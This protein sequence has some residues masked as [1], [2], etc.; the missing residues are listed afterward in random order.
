MKNKVRNVLAA[1]VLCMS[2]IA[3]PVTAYASTGS[4]TTPP[5]LSATLNDDKLAVEASD[6]MSGVEAVYVDDTRINSLVNGKGTVALKD[7]AGDG[8]EVTVYAVDY[9][10]N[11]SKEV[12]LDN[13]YYEE[14]AQTQAASSAAPQSSS[15]E[16][17]AA[18][19]PSS[20]SASGNSGSSQVAQIPSTSQEETE[21]SSESSATEDETESAVP[22]GAFTPEGTGTVLDSATEQEDDKQFYTIT[23]ADGNVFYLII[24]GKRD[25]ENVYFLNG[26]T[27]EDLLSLAQQDNGSESAIEVVTCNCA[28]KCEAGAVN[29]DCPVCKNDLNGCLGKVTEE[30]APEETEQPE[31]E[32]EKSGGNTGMIIFLVIA[33]VAAGGLG[34]YFKI[35]R[36]KQQAAMDED[37]F[38]DDG[39][40]EDDEQDLAYSDEPSYD[41]DEEP[42]KDG[43]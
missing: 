22:E 30:P 38:E 18:P 12:K 4:D 16:T 8:K 28:E 14:P 3:L 43:R 15:G 27:E 42:T 17:Q 39:Y 33:L 21:A 26:V 40:G 34:Y 36:P 11:R 29:T 2:A 9:S 5:T 20:N 23:T 19:S 41:E 24:D 32:T 31:A 35:V 7:Y 6:D 10:G 37:E 25:S 13:P 1:L